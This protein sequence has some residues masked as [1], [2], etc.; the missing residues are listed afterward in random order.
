MYCVLWTSLGVSLVL[1][2]LVMMVI[3]MV[4]LVRTMMMMM[5]RILVSMVLQYQW[6]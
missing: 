5:R 6:P 2:Y 3:T 1:Q 4:I